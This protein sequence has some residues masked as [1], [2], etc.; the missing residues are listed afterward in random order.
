MITIKNDNDIEMKN[1]IHTN[2]RKSNREKCQ[3]LKNN[4]HAD[5]KISDIKNSNFLAFDNDRLI[6]GAIGFVQYNWY[7]LDLLYVDEKYR[8]QNVGTNLIKQIEAFAEK[9][10]LTG[11]RM[12]TWDFQ[13]RGF[14]E[15]NGYTVFAE[16][17][18]C[19][20]GT[21]EYFLK[22]EFYKKR[23]EFKMVSQNKKLKYIQ[24]TNENLEIAY[25]I[26][27]RQWKSEPDKQNFLNKASN[28][29][30][31]NISFIVY[32]KNTPIGIT[33]VYTE[34]ID[35]DS[36]W[37]DWF[38][39]EPEYRKKGLGEQ[40]LRDTIEYAKGLER[41]LYFRV[42]TTYWEGRPAV[43]LYDK[44]MNIKEEYT[45]ENEK[46]DN[47]TLIYTYNF[48]DKAENWNNRY[49]GLNEYYTKLKNNKI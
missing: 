35:K 15:K 9:E 3:W 45:V 47:P 1:I 44:V 7:F 25:N 12:E 39:V 24:V 33:G 19:P 14:Y 16:I 17:K 4:S 42:E 31:D 34:D 22:K 41:F 6:G 29:K 43:S 11:V 10:N 28:A 18:D 21:I 30:E 37:L 32:Y 46:T 23:L 48:T 5:I 13:A 8:G 38:C 26:Q 27:K 49:L 40:I 20:P 2:L 36:I